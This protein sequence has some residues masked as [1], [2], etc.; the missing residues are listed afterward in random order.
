MVKLKGGGGGGLFTQHLLVFSW[1]RCPLRYEG[2]RYSEGGVMGAVHLA[3]PTLQAFTLSSH[4]L[5]NLIPHATPVKV[6]NPQEL[7]LFL[8]QNLRPNASVPSRGSAF[9]YTP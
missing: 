6:T 7:Q 8:T 9:A 1:E 4:I 3:I 2:A 5:Q